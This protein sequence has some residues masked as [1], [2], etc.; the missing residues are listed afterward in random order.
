LAINLISAKPEFRNPFLHYSWPVIPLI[1]LAVIATVSQHG[2]WF[3]RGRSVV[4]W[5]AALALI[6]LAARGY[7]ATSRQVGDAATV[8]EKRRAVEMIDDQGGV[9]ATSQTAPHLSERTVIQ[10]VYDPTDPVFKMPTDD[11][12]GPAGPPGGERAKRRSL[13]KRGPSKV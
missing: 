4:V 12:L 13:R 10:F 7:E 1:F 5:S 8:D 9:L 6:G 11:R 2:G 3:H